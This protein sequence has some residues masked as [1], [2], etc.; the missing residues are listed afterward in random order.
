[1]VPWVVNFIIYVCTVDKGTLRTLEVDCYLDA[2][3]VF[4]SILVIKSFNNSLLLFLFTMLSMSVTGQ[5][6]S[7][8][9]S[10]SFIFT[11]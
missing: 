8:F 9:I 10:H 11:M 6:L 1:M 7:Q 4:S 3:D 2:M 5:R